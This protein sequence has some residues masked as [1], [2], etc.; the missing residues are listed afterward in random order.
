MKKNS[1]SQIDFTTFEAAVTDE[2]SRETAV[3][4]LTRDEAVDAEGKLETSYIIE[5][6]ESCS[7][8]M[9]GRLSGWLDRRGGNI[10]PVYEALK[11][12]QTAKEYMSMYFY[13]IFLYGFV[14]WRVPFRVTCLAA[15][16]DSL[17]AYMD[18][19]MM[20]F[21][22]FLA[23]LEEA[24]TPGEESGESRETAETEPAAAQNEI[25]VSAPADDSE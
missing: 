10:R 19:F 15:A 13:L 25:P 21:E 8:S 5:L 11:K 18:E 1:F 2:M 3:K 14:R 20:S 23:D 22:E 9:L 7:D 24:E 16:P 12:L 17:K 6:A 4:K